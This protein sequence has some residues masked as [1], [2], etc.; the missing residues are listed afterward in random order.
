M[1]GNKVR[2]IKQNTGEGF[3]LELW[4]GTGNGQVQR[5]CLRKDNAL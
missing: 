3:L 5:A 4:W 2:R 1:S